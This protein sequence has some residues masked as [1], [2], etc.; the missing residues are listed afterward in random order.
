MINFIVLDDIKE[1]INIFLA[2]NFGILF[3]FDFSQT[4]VL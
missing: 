2:M 3:E 1:N 4:I